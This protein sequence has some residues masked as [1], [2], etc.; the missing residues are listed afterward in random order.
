[1]LDDAYAADRTALT[2]VDPCN[3]FL[4]EG[5]KLYDRIKDT[6]EAAGMFGNLRRLLA[7]V[8]SA[9]IPVFVVPHHRSHPG[10]F[11]GW[12]HM[13]PVQAAASHGR[14]FEV[15]S[16]GGEWHPESGEQKCRPCGGPIPANHPAHANGAI[17]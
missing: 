12:R 4:S 1:M 14:L 13:N 2:V 15:E 5:G 3:N 16:W 6:T 9:G 11:A 17:A 8:Q 7:T 10:D